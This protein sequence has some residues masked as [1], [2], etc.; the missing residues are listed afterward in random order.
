MLGLSLLALG[1]LA[2]AHASTGGRALSG[3]QPLFSVDGDDSPRISIGD[4]TVAEG[5]SGTTSMTFTVSRSGD[6]HGTSSVHYETEGVT[7]TS[8][9]DF[10]PA[11]GMLS[12]PTGVTT[13]TLTVDVTGDRLDESDE[14]L[15]VN[16]SNPTGGHIV[17]GQGLGTITDDDSSPTADS[18]S[19]AT[20][21]DTALPVTLSA[22]GDGDPL[23]YTIVNAPGHGTLAG[24]G[25]SQTYSPEPNYNGPDSF[26]FRASDG[27]NDSNLATVSITVNPVNDPPVASPNSA[28]L[29]EDSFALV[30]LPAT[31]ADGDPLTYSI[32]EQPAHGALSGSGA[33]RTY[34]PAPNYNGPDSFTFEANDGTADSNTATVSLT[35]LP[36]NDAPV[37]VDDAASVAED[38]SIP[39]AVLANDSDVDGDA[40]LGDV[41]RC[42]R[43]RHR[44][45]PAGRDRPLHACRELQ[46]RRQL[47]VRDL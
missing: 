24:S 44:G 17:D 30:P 8:G 1:V 12:F 20:D 41:G 22:T 2:S 38:G 39:V 35:V 19:V 10:A 36:V 42:A 21:E 13:R 9:V 5:D 43:P 33:S 14:V 47:H 31:D 6:S 7:A 26:T 29:A 16:L 28:L 45:A 34:T 3:H 40:P 4:A 11:S 37:A 15:A 27:V 23:T 25:A 32:V 18:Q 46:R